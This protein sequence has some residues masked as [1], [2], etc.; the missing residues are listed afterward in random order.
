MA[1]TDGGGRGGGDMLELSAEPWPR[2]A[3]LSMA[4]FCE[5]A[6]ENGADDDEDGGEGDDDI[7]FELCTTR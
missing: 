1:P 4:L 7:K 6:D 2:P 3:V 5:D